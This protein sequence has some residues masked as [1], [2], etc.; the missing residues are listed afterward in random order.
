LASSIALGD[1][2]N[3][4]GP[5]CALPAFHQRGI[6]PVP[7]WHVLYQQRT[8]D[9][10]ICESSGSCSLCAHVSGTECPRRHELL[11]RPWRTAGLG[12]PA[13]REC[14]SRRRRPRTQ[15]TARPVE[16]ISHRLGKSIAS[17]ADTLCPHRRGLGCSF[18]SRRTYSRTRVPSGS[19]FISP[20]GK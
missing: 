7:R 20:S 17:D 3:E 8:A 14:F 9:L 13:A 2:A 18:C 5:V 10:S 11:L 4:T 6:C 12:L 16:K 15:A 1:L 19:L